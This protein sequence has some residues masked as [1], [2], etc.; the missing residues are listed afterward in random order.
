MLDF[1]SFGD[2]SKLSIWVG[3]FNFEK[4]LEEYVEEE[5]DDDDKC[6]SLFLEQFKIDW[7]DHDFQEIGFYDN[8]LTKDG[9]MEHSWAKTFIPNVD[10]KLLMGNN[11]VIIV[12]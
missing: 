3:N 5:Y 1:E 11:S 10:D 6:S 8:G 4:E 7:I 2:I 12:Y 9:L